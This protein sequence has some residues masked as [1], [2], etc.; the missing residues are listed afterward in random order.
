[1]DCAIAKYCRLL[2]S[3]VERL[4]VSA[5]SGK[6]SSSGSKASQLLN[7]MNEIIRKTWA[8]PTHSHELGYILCN[9][10]KTRGGLD[11]LMSNCV[12]NDHELQFSSARL[13]DL[14]A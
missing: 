7:R 12:A 13:L 6:S 10:L 14:D 8:V 9:T 4:K 5:D 1:M 2:D 11:L 3:F